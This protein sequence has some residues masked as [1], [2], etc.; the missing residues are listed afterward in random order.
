NSSRIAISAGISP[1]AMA[2]SLRPHSARDRSATEKS[3][4]VALAWGAALIAPSF[5]YEKRVRE[6]R[7]RSDPEPGGRPLPP[8]ATLLGDGRHCPRADR[9]LSSPD[10]RESHRPGGHDRRTCLHRERGRPHRE[11]AGAV[12]GS[13]LTR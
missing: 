12:P 7:S 1:S 10:V 6:R 4:V 9:C 13:V 11:A 8:V 3:A 5:L 2:I